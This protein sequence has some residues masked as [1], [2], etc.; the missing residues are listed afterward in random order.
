MLCNNRI[1]KEKRPVDFVK[2]LVDINILRNVTVE[3][4]KNIMLR[5]P[6]NSL[7]YPHFF[8]PFFLQLEFLQQM[9]LS[10]T[11]NQNDF[12]ILFRRLLIQFKKSLK[13]LTFQSE[14]QKKYCHYIIHDF[15]HRYEI[16]K[17]MFQKKF[18]RNIWLNHD[19]KAFLYFLD[20]YPL[21]PNLVSESKVYCKNMVEN[22]TQTKVPSL[23]THICLEKNKK[24]SGFHNEFFNHVDILYL[25]SPKDDLFHYR[26]QIKN[27]FISKIN[28]FS[29][30]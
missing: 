27:D 22:F 14:T 3:T 8:F 24:M 15:I 20:D 28:N 12:C 13:S 1:L 2:F 6:L 16:V 18:G 17:E 19:L 29:T 21:T 9:E 10:S 4:D 26:N 7:H 30:S 23:R 25:F 5:P 11:I